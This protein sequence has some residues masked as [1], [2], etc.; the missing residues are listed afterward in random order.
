M[1]I[2]ALF[3]DVGNT[4]LFPNRKKMLQALHEREVFPAEDLLLKIERETKHEFD[5]LLESHTAVDR[6]FWHI[7]YTRLLK[8]LD[9][10]DESVRDDL[11]ARTRISA[12]W[13]DI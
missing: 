10:A 1:A 8:E 6:G 13:C 3:F 12:N 9:I 5:Q 7:F 11:V 4:L 2:K